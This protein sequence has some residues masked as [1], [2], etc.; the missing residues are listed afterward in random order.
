MRIGGK[1]VGLNQQRGR[2]LFAILTFYL[3]LAPHVDAIQVEVSN[4]PDDNLSLTLSAI[5]RAKRSVHL[6]IYEFTSVPIAEALISQVQRGVS[7]D[8]LQEGQIVGGV[9]AISKGIQSDIVHAMKR[10]GTKHHYYE[11]T[12]KAGGTRR[13]RFDHAKYATIDGSILLI[14]SENFSPT[15]QP[16]SGS[17][18]N[19]GWEVLIHDTRIVNEFEALFAEDSKTSYHDVMELTLAHQ[20]AY[21]GGVFLP[22]LSA[23]E[24]PPVSR[25]HSVLNGPKSFEAS[26]IR[27]ITSPDSSLD[28]I[29]ALLRQAKRSIDLELMTFKSLWNGAG[30][31]SPLVDE[32][33]AA[34]RRGVTVRILLNDETVFQQQVD[35]ASSPINPVTA[36]LF[37]RAAQAEKL[38][39]SARIA[40]VKAMGVDY[41]H[42]K[43]LLIDGNVTLV[44]SINW[45]WNSIS[46][47]RETA[48]AITC[49]DVN[50]YY[51]HLFERDWKV[52]G[53]SRFLAPALAHTLE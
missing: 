48:V 43:G 37:N 29:T 17:I 52:S 31:R 5:Q 9:S 42:N 13:Y 21:F 27:V 50:R 18:G 25:S 44:S 3:L 19:R 47:N 16:T 26:A 23:D 38:K 46:N 35:R 1:M 7:T 40:D 51:T 34:A 39:L 45:N 36:E 4:A 11:M 49:P 33:L 12:S 53:G 10:A 30:T 2:G 41:I 6:N 28:G 15:G 32:V 8:I 22:L 20:R 14:S 24:P